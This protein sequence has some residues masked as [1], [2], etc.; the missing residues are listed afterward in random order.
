MILM[1]SISELHYVARLAMR[2]P[3]ELP[4]TVTRWYQ[5]KKLANNA[6][7]K[8]EIHSD[9]PEFLLRGWRD[10]SAA[11]A[12]FCRGGGRT[13]L[14]R[15]KIVMCGDFNVPQCLRY[16]G[17]GM[18]EL[19]AQMDADFT[20][21]THYQLEAT[22]SELQTASSLIIYRLQCN[23]VFNVLLY[24][25]RRLG[26]PVFYDI[27]DPL[28]SIECISDYGNIDFTPLLNRSA[29]MLEACA[30]GVAMSS[31][32]YLIASTPRLAQEMAR[33]ARRPA[34]VRRN[35]PSQQSIENGEVL[36]PRGENE[37]PVLIFPSGSFGH[38]ADLNAIAEEL[39]RFFAGAPQAK[40]RIVGQFR[41]E[42]LDK[43]LRKYAEF[44][45]FLEYEQYVAALSAA[46][47]ILLPLADERFN[48]CK[49]GVRFIDTA[50][51]GGVTIASAVGDYPNMIEDGVNGVLV[52]NST[53]WCAVLNRVVGDEALR[54][55]IRRGARKSLR[56]T[57]SSRLDWPVVDPKLVSL[58]R[59]EIR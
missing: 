12:F 8:P 57:F 49:S 59:G 29:M 35:F 18:G 34:F 19:V 2:R 26:I 56:E 58:L 32:D 5:R 1:P 16:R 28:F 25:A 3:A 27:D 23:H 14:R 55:K 24:E 48:R 31:C 52:E 53:D 17:T 13:L 15:P 43:R 44:V 4:G 37:H 9:N 10:I 30:Y 45:P 47:A 46:T 39:V 38:E 36:A 51:I 22:V 11:D 7:H 42:T 6:E 20:C 50:S 40:L 21:F 33:Y 54:N 41:P